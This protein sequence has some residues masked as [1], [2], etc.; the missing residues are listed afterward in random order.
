MYRRTVLCTGYELGQ[1]QVMYG[2]LFDKFGLCTGALAPFSQ[3]VSRESYVP[4]YVPG[5]VPACPSG[6]DVGC[7]TSRAKTWYIVAYITPS[8]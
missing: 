6:W 5:Y 3:D 4:G 1:M 8:T 7:T 2:G